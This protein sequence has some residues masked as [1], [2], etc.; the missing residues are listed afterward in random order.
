MASTSSFSSKRVGDGEGERE[1]GN[2]VG[3]NRLSKFENM[4]GGE[5]CFGNYIER[6]LEF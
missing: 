6:T 5:T 4:T 2:L 1:S 3:E